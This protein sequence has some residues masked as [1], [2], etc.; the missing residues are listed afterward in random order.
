MR[1]Y[2]HRPRLGA[3]IQPGLSPC[4]PV[5]MPTA[6]TRSAWLACG[7]SGVIHYV[8]CPWVLGGSV[9]GWV[10]YL[11]ALPLGLDGALPMGLAGAL[12][13]C[14][15]CERCMLLSFPICSRAA[16]A[17]GLPATKTT[18]GGWSLM[19]ACERTKAEFHFWCGAPVCTEEFV[20]GDCLHNKQ[21]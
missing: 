3:R 21:L 14:G 19:H 16:S 9:V 8:R 17:K 2:H 13:A 12:P 15:H 6:T 10:L 7:A 18:A 20:Q 4:S 11:P 5:P 1:G